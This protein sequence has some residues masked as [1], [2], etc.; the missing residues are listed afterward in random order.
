MKTKL[1]EAEARVTS[2]REATRCRTLRLCE[3][4][5]AGTYEEL[6]RAQKSLDRGKAELEKA[7]RALNRLKSARELAESSSIT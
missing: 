7:E 3:L 1:A 4:L 6:A 5:E 2:W